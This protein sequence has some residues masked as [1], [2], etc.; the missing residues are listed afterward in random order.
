MPD[1]APTPSGP[2]WPRVAAAAVLVSVATFITLQIAAMALYPGGTWMDRS[3]R[4]HDWLR[5]FFCDLSAGVAL[6]GAPNPGAGPATAAV[7]ALSAGLF[8]FWLIVPQLFARRARLGALVRPLGL[9]SAAVLPL[10]PLLSSARWGS[11]HALVIFLA[12]V[13]GFAAAALAT[14]ALFASPAARRPHGYLAGAM[15]LAAL[16]DGALYAEHV[17]SGSAVPP[18]AL[19]ALQKLAALL[20]LACMVTVSVTILR[21]RGRRGAQL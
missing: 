14:L 19:P 2:R 1:A 18:S 6:N 9:L 4:G 11:I 17:A 5:N 7:L 10:V 16:I 15:L 3:A 8:A 12:A 13:P 20:L 21:D